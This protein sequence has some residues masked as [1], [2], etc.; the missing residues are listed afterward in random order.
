MRHIYF[1][2]IIHILIILLFSCTDSSQDAAIRTVSDVSSVAQRVV[3]N[4]SDRKLMSYG[5][6]DV[7]KAPYSA[8]P[9]GQKD[10]TTILQKAINDARDAQIVC[11]LPAG[12]YLVSG[13]IEGI[14]GI[15]NWDHWP[16]DGV[17]NPWVAEA[18][19]DYPCV[20]A[21]A[22]GDDRA[23]IVLADH[24]SHFSNPENPQAIFYFWARS[25]QSFGPKDVNKPQPNINFNQKI[26]NLDFDLGQGNPGAIAIDLRGAEGASVEDIRIR[27]SG[28][29]A[30]IRNAPGSGGAMHGIAVTGGQYGLYLTGTQPSPLVSDLALEDQ[31]I[32]S[33]YYTSRGPL[34]IVGAH[35]IG[36]GIRGE[37]LDRPWN[38]ALNLIDAVIE[39]TSDSVAIRSERSVA[40]NNVWVYNAPTIIQ[41]QNCE[42]VRGQT[43]GWTLLNKY[44][45]G[46]NVEFNDRGNRFE[47]TDKIWINKRESY[48]P[49]IDIETRES[50]PPQ[51]FYHRHKIPAFINWFGI[52]T[53]NVKEAP[54]L[55]RGDGQTD[56]YEAIQRAINEND[57]VFL[58]KGN[59]RVS[60]SLELKPG[61]KLTGVSN[62]FTVIS[63]ID[64]A[65]NYSDP[66]NPQPLIKTVNNADAET[67]L[68]MIKLEVPVRNPCVYALQWLAGQASVVRN[69]YP[70]RPIWHPDAIAMDVPMVLIEG[71]GGGRWYTQTLLGWWSQAPAYRHLLVRDTEQYLQFYHLQPQHARCRYMVEFQN[72]ENIDIYS[73]KAESDVTIL[74]LSKC[75]DIRLFGCSGYSSPHPGWALIQIDQSDNI[76]MTNIDMMLGYG[77]YGALGIGYHPKSWN[78]ICD[79]GFVLNGFQ[80]FVWYEH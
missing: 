35:I 6:L 41:I 24:C 58:P 27:A 51:D 9:T 8:D 46:T 77:G 73:M 78:L 4:Y 29:F 70:I 71:S 64:T 76:L 47:H 1:F 20:L 45:Q 30:G 52:H 55:A 11:Y 63:P 36:A 5:F 25:M 7:T 65:D 32:S 34:T 40:L 2:I 15:I 16:Y 18:S 14:S 48:D 80:Q 19:F 66:N 61:T 62:L 21:G 75:R 17:A 69:I 50:G 28:A 3:K 37:K 39:L 49:I 43:G 60:R 59:Y 79:D 68:E 26:L 72:A 12:R 56:D 54:Y 44:A 53:V 42:P 57:L 38:S 23:T 67:M 33:V 10:V 22:R 13:T 31:E 74:R